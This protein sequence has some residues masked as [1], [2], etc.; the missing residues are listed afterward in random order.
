MPV[1]V[2]RRFTVL[3][4]ACPFLSILLSSASATCAAHMHCT[5]D[6][7]HYMSVFPLCR[8]K[9][10]PTGNTAPL[11]SRVAFVAQMHRTASRRAGDSAGQGTAS[12]IHSSIESDLEP[13][14][15]IVFYFQIHVKTSI[16]S[17]LCLFVVCLCLTKQN[18]G[19]CSSRPSNH[20]SPVPCLRSTVYPIFF[21]LHR[22]P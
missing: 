10:G 22:L 5:Q 2:G 7:H 20:G 19:Y 14:I 11:A 4:S 3:T 15:I 18:S 8:P 21:L 17:L 1:W 13:R 12:S 6:L 9:K 16:K